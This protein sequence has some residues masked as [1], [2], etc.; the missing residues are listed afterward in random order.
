MKIVSS[1]IYDAVVGYELAQE[2]EHGDDY[3]RAY[4]T[5][6]RPS[7]GMRRV[8]SRFSAVS[9]VDLFVEFRQ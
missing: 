5:E 9:G 1:R 7:Q 8:R 4:P 2:C 3:Q 6:H